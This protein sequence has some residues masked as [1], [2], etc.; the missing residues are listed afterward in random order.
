MTLI[1]KLKKNKAGFTLIELIVVIAILAILAAILVP[2]MIAYLNSARQQ[3][4]ESDLRAAYS[5]ACAAYTAI[6]VDDPT[7][8]GNAVAVAAG[9]NG[10]AGE[11]ATLIGA[12]I[13][14]GLTVT[15]T[16]AGVT[17]ISMTCSDGG[18][19]SYDGSE[20]TNGGQPHEH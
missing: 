4:E 20:F 15:W 6:A 9:A 8:T 10:V 12:N 7:T 3:Q 5:S 17:D 16:T 18:T 19:V 11:T 1:Q 2:A 14:D 13:P